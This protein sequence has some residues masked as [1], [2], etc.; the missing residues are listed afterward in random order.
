MDLS[1]D[2]DISFEVCIPITHRLPGGQG[3]ECRELPASRVAFIT[4]RGPY[5]TIWNAH[6]ELVAWVADHGYKP[7]GPVREI[8]IVDVSDTDDPREWVTELA[9][10]IGG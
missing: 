7:A 6:T 9:I 4:F 5:D 8:G 3:V 1:Q 10:P 2:D